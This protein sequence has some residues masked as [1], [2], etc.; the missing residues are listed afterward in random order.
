MKDIWRI[1]TFTKEL[2][3]YYTG[4]SIFTILGAVTTQLQPLF[5]K[6]AIDEITKLAGGATAN[7]ALVAWFAA[8]IFLADV[9]LTLFS[10]VGGYIG[11][12]MS[13]RLQKLLG[14]R[15]YKHMLSLPQRYFDTELSGTII[16]RMTRGVSQ[17]SQFMQMMSNNFLQFIFSTVLSLAVVAYFSWPVA[18]MLSF[19]YPIFIWLTA[20]TST[21]WMEYQK[22]INEQQDI[23]SGRF[24]ESIS[25]ARVVKTFLQ[26]ARELLFF[27]KRYDTVVTT[28]K[29]QSKLW[30]RQD[31]VRRLVLNFITL[32]VYVY[33]FV[34]T[35]H[36][37][38]SVGTMVLLIQ[39]TALIRIPL[40]SISFLVDQTQRAV[41]NT[42]DY[43]AAL[44]VQ[45][46]IA[47]KAG[48]RDLRVADGKIVFDDVCFAYD[49]DKPV[50]KHVS[51]T[52]QPDTK[53]ALVGESGEGKTTLTNLLLRLYDVTEG[54]I[55]IDGQNIAAVTQ[56]SLRGAIGVVFQEPALFSG[57]IRENIAY[58]MPDATDERVMAAARA[59]NAHDFIEKFEKGYE[60]EIG[61]RGLKL[62]GGQKQRIAIARALLKDAPILILDE[63]TSSLDSKSEHMVQEALER[64]MKGR[65]T[66]IIAHRLSTIQHVDQIVTLRSGKVDEVGT[67]AALAATDGIYAQLLQLQLGA[68][69]DAQLK[70]KLKKYDIAS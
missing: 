46:E 50:I 14:E 70:K 23:A 22:T 28:T 53:V 24:A 49:V 44:D 30:H 20:R 34:Q 33:I 40:F 64:L 27:T 55:T 63:A 15:Y 6:G 13:A 42:K 45:P 3:P 65:T 58:G 26:E 31:V 57:T 5:V 56:S 2:R 32:G 59:A 69:S 60:T 43:F 61:E 25:Q 9:L 62:S 39:Y 16:N 7:V 11:D 37:E 47:D 54:S 21:K 12:M 52:V 35:A 4:I 1:V 8:A 17:I 68:T 67:P 29:P 51:F 10:N 36:G 41:S 18:I 19:L 66:L 38:Y 48:A